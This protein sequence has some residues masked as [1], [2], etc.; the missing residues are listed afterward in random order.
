MHIK[1]A[2]KSFFDFFKVTKTETYNKLIFDLGNG[3]WDIPELKKL[4]KEILPKNSLEHVIETFSHTSE[5]HEIE[6]NG[7]KKCKIYADK[8]RV[9]QVLINLLTNAVKYSP[10]SNK[11]ILNLESKAK[12]VTVCV[13]DFGIGIPK[14][15][16]DMILKDFIE[17]KESK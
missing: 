14:E 11:I 5:S 7:S 1:T 2:N 12:V 13:K 17:S 6:F 9:E 3:Q 10:D 16:Q 15:Q 8:D 4:L